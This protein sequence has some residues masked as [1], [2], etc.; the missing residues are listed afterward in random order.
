MRYW[1]GAESLPLSRQVVAELA[2]A[3]MMAPSIH[4]P[5]PW[6]IHVS[7]ERQIIEL[8]ANPD[9]ALECGDPTGRV[10]HVACGAAV[11]NLRVAAAMAGREPIV[12]LLP[13]PA[14]ASLLAT[15]RLA[16]THVAE[17]GERELHAAMTASHAGLGPAAGERV[18]GAVLAELADA[19]GTEG[20]TLRMLDNPETA[21]LL[22]LAQNAAPSIPAFVQDS[23][24]LAVLATPMGCT[25]GSLLAGQAMERV[26]LTA[27]ARGIAAQPF[28]PLPG[29][30]V[31]Q[32]MRQHFGIEQPQM[33]LRFGYAPAADPRTGLL[34]AGLTNAPIVP[35]QRVPGLHQLAQ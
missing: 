27:T 28:V 35:R 29:S 3:A 18:P 11:F 15:I 25:T 9:H 26:L 31:W 16:G 22:T 6:R 12:V 21:L 13:E 1:V 24:Q 20:A 10:A 32:G 5:Q 14:A 2:R 30:G 8:H 7:P 17:P 4:R 34:A 33:I 23:P 19:A